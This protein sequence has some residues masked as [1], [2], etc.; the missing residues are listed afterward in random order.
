MPYRIDANSDL[1]K[2]FKAW[3]VYY[4]KTQVL[5]L[6]ESETEFIYNAILAISPGFPRSAFQ[7]FIKYLGVHIGPDSAAHQ[8]TLPLTGYLD[9]VT[10]LRG[11]DAGFILKTFLCIHGN[12]HPRSHRC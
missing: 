12:P 9:T 1:E 8:W 3:G 7:R 2:F 10:F 6:Q 5:A 4:D 11:I